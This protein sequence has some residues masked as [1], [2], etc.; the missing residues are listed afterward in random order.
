MKPWIWKV[1]RAGGIGAVVVFLLPY[2]IKLLD[3]LLQ[4]LLHWEYTSGHSFYSDA[5]LVSAVVS[6][7][8]A[9]VNR[10]VDVGLCVSAAMGSIAL[11]FGAYVFSAVVAWIRASIV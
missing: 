4:V 2:G 8:L 3:R 1:A 11:V 9:Y 5:S 7:Y 6:D 10:V